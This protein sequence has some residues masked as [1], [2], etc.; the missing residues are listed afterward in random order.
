MHIWEKPEKSGIWKHKK[1][2]GS[3]EPLLFI[4]SLPPECGVSQVHRRVIRRY[5][6]GIGFP[7]HIRS[8]P[9]LYQIEEANVEEILNNPK[10]KYYQITQDRCC[11]PE[12]AEAGS[13]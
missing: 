2:S 4:F 6:R 7:H 5:F 13:A 8:V 3:C 1:S 12:A 11:L 9:V 10:R